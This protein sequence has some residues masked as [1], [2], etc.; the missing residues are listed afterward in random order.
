MRTAVYSDS[1]K[2]SLYSD[3]VYCPD[4]LFFSNLNENSEQTTRN[5]KSLTFRGFQKE[6]GHL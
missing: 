1:N 6:K 4:R 5:I 2:I 3:I